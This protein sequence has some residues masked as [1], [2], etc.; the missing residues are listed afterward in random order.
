ME[1]Y[2]GFYDDDGNPI[3]PNL[4]PK[5]ALCLGCKKNDDPNEEMLCTMTRL[6]QRGE[7][8]FECFAYE[9]LG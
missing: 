7:T 1:K 3:N 9:S 8:D 5:P 4:F 6:D 2:F